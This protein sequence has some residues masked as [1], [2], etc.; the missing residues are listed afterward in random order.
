MKARAFWD[1]NILIYWIEGASA[2]RDSIAA[3]RDWQVKEEIQTV[4]SAL[5]LGEILVHPERKGRGD[6]ARDYSG[7]IRAMGCLG[8]GPDE[9]EIFANIRARYPNVRP[10]DAIQLACAARARVEWFVT[11]DARLGG[12]TVAGIGRI[13]DLAEWP[14][15]T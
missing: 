2:W 15:G 8:F 1:T 4:T 12:V 14:A 13:L 5:S 9:A 6:I 11:N 10:P 7:L 3:L